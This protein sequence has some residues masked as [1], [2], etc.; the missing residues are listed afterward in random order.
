M[1]FFF[2]FSSI[3]DITAVISIQLATMHM[4]TII[5]KT[6]KDNLF[7]QIKKIKNKTKKLKNKIKQIKILKKNKIN[8][9]TK[10]KK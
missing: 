4:I 10:N 1:G 5:S 6:E 3:N 9:K 8:S 2:H 7:V